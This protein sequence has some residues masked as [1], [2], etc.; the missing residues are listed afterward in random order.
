MNPKKY[1]TKT[2]K[3]LTLLIFIFTTIEI[4]GIPTGIISVVYNLRVA[5]TTLLLTREFKNPIGL[6]FTLFNSARWQKRGLCQKKN[7]KSNA[8]GELFS[9]FYMKKPLGDCSW[10]IRGDFAFARVSEVSN[11]QSL[12]LV[13]TDDF[14]ITGGYSWLLHSIVRCTFSG[15]F[16]F[17][18]HRDRSLE[19]VQFGSGHLGL[20]IQLDAAVNYCPKKYSVHFAARLIGTVPRNAIFLSHR[21]NYNVG[22]LLDLF[23]AHHATVGNHCFEFGYNPKFIFA[24]G[25]SPNNPRLAYRLNLIRNNFYMFYKYGFEIKSV[26]SA[27]ALGLSLCSDVVP[28]TGQKLIVFVWAIL[29]FGF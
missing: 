22:E 23:L 4:F 21:Y 18:T 17:P 27:S 10:Y 28:K 29:G 8:L 15:L 24:S 12:A 1:L 3:L 6:E 7:D 13:E 9:L 11:N 25:L 20:G 2:F 26:N 19:R 14:L 16:G 5:E